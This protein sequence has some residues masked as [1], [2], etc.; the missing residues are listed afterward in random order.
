[1]CFRLKKLYLLPLIALTVKVHGMDARNLY[2]PGSNITMAKKKY[3]C[4]GG[5]LYIHVN[6][7]T[8]DLKELVDILTTP[9]R[10][11][12]VWIRPQHFV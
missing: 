11:V 4:V 5:L 8:Y 6:I 3:V 2:D 12:S 7:A 9:K 10:A 1:M